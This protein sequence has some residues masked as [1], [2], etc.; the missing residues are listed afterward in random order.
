MII[1]G[2]AA[3]GVGRQA[4]IEGSV[5][6]DFHVDGRCELNEDGI[7]Q[8]EELSGIVLT[9]TDPDGVVLGETTTGALRIESLEYGCRY[10]AEYSLTLTRASSY[11]VEFDPPTPHGFPFGGYFEGAEE[12][13]TQDISHA[14]LAAAGFEWSFEAPPQYVVP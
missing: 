12:L 3:C 5:F 7:G 2:L 10:L 14:E 13:E 11:T 9:F 4:T 6:T 1:L 8:P